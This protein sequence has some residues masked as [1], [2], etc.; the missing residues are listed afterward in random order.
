MQSLPPIQ[1]NELQKDQI[2]WKWNE[3]GVYTVKSCYR[4]IQEGPYIASQ[5]KII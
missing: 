3:A 5:M 1:F 2:R 4:A